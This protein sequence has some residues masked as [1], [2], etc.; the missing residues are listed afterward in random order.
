[1]LEHGLD[2]TLLSYGAD[3]A[4][5]ERYI[6]RP[7][8]KLIPDLIAG[9][10]ESHRRFFRQLPP[11]IDEHDFFM[12]HAS[13]PTDEKTE[14]PAVSTRVR[15]DSRLRHEVLWGRLTA[16]DMARR[17]AWRRTGF[18]GHSPVGNY[19]TA[20]GSGDLPLVGPQI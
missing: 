5:I 4:L 17:K 11:V 13:W 9:V 8:E 6:E 18:F 2:K 7:S 20:H 10:P 14:L 3:P 19:T 15:A 1:F 12:A 16:D